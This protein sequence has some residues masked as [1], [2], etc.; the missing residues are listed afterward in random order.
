MAD[1]EQTHPWLT[2]SINLSRA[3]ARL[4]LM[5]G[6]CNALCRQIAGAPVSPGFRDEF[7]RHAIARG[8]MDTAALDG[9]TLSEEEV[10]G[11]LFEGR[12]VPPSKRYLAQ[13][14]EN[15]LAGYRYI[16]S[17]VLAQGQHE[18]N[19]ATIRELNRIVL[20]RFVLDPGC[21]PGMIRDHEVDIPSH[22]FPVAPAADCIELTDQLCQWLNG[23]TFQ[24]PRGLEIVYGILA[25]VMA[26][27]YLTWIHP[28][29]RGNNRTTSLVMFMLLAGSGVP[30]VAA[31]HFSRLYHETRYDYFRHIETASDASG[32]ILPFIMYSVQGFLDGLAGQVRLIAGHQT[33]LAWEQQIAAVFGNKTSLADIRRKELAYDLAAVAQ[34]VPV[35]GLSGISPRMA[36]YYSTKTQKTVLRDIGDLERAGLVERTPLGVRARLETVQGFGDGLIPE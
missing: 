36:K 7:V 16:L 33:R 6:E 26:G 12:E 8:T 11:I 2:F 24:A 1:Y 29:S 14:N 25:A 18:L 4:W 9:N 34:P 30:V 28:F 31:H 27:L 21:E 19:L 35:A 10:R 22:R 23:E 3:P 32:K 15:M 5:L 20:D 17:H 13:E